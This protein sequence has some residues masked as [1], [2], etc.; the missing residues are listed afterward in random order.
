MSAKPFC[1][2]TLAC[3]CALCVLCRA[4]SLNAL[5]PWPLPSAHAQRKRCGVESQNAFRCADHDD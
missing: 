4:A 2:Y 5:K 3:T 1:L